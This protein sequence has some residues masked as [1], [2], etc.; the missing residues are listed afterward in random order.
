MQKGSDTDTQAQNACLLCLSSYCTY[1]CP[2][3]YCWGL[4]YYCKN[5]NDPEEDT[6]FLFELYNGGEPMLL[7][8]YL[9]QAPPCEQA[10]LG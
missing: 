10:A 5:A 6:I 4:A 1:N 7:Q 9:L 8:A 3:Q 2:R